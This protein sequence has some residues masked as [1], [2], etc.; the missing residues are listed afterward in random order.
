MVVLGLVALFAVGSGEDEDAGTSDLLGGRVPLVAGSTLDGG[1]YDIDDARG[2][3]VLVNFF[4]TWCPGCI[5]EHPELIAFDEWG[6]ETGRAEVVA[7]VFNDPPDAV[8]SFFSEN[9]GDWPVLDEP[10]VPVAFQVSRIPESF[11][12]SPS[13]QVVQH[14][15][16]EVDA[17]ALISAIEAA[18]PA[19]GGGGETGDASEPAGGG[20]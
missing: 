13:G 14:V 17:A 9:G 19:P 1:T 20:S 2:D 4:A 5:A 3:W 16:G 7:V 15:R 11:L 18:E 8:A 6:E 12:V 10:S